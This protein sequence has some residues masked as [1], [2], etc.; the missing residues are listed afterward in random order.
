[1]ISRPPLKWDQSLVRLFLLSTNFFL[2]HG[3][4]PE[5]HRIVFCPSRPAVDAKIMSSYCPIGHRLLISDMQVSYC[6]IPS[7]IRRY[8]ISRRVK[9]ISSQPVHT[10]HFISISEFISFYRAVAT[11]QPKGSQFAP[12]LSPR[13]TVQVSLSKTP[14]P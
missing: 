3:S 8:C 5:T 14:N 6:P 10:P 12:G 4:S 7:H 9:S 11:W 13:V 2:F 1:M